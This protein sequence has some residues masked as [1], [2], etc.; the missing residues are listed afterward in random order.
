MNS[1]RT[2]WPAQYRTRAGDVRGKAESTSDQALRETL[3]KEAEVWELMAAY[4]EKH[5]RTSE[6]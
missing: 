5:P 1:M 6:A 2:D 4:V 3:L